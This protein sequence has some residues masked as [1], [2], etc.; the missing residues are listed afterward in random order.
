MSVLTALSSLH[1]NSLLFAVVLLV[2]SLVSCVVYWNIWY[3]CLYIVSSSQPFEKKQ[4][5][6]HFQLCLFLCL[7]PGEKSRMINYHLWLTTRNLGRNQSIQA[8]ET[9][10]LP[11]C[12]SRFVCVCVC[13]CVCVSWLPPINLYSVL[14]YKLLAIIIL[15]SL[16]L[17]FTHSLSL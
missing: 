14:F 2:F 7:V 6:S 10:L 5:G 3:N 16:F 12:V 9:C 4:F 13:V 15:N 11:V 1:C 8:Y 17:T